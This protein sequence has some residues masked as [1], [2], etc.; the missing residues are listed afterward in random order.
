MFLN[1]IDLPIIAFY[2]QFLAKYSTLQF[3]KHQNF[4]K[5]FYLA[6]WNFE[7]FRGDRSFSK[8][9]A[10]CKLSIRRLIVRQK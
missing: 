6:Y 5:T 1:T 9:K 3:C 8:L 10:R 4:K 2:H 7:L